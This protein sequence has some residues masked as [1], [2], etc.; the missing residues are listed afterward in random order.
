MTT[1]IFWCLW[2]T[3]SRPDDP[4]TCVP[5][6]DIPEEYKRMVQCTIG[7]KVHQ[8]TEAERVSR[9]E[10]LGKSMSEIYDVSAS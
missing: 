8:V 4:F 7:G 10:I 1:K 5:L 3:L 9:E 2:L 6:Q